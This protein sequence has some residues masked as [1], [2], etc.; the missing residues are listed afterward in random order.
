[1]ARKIRI[2]TPEEMALLRQ[3]VTEIRSCIEKL[4]NR[5]EAITHDELPSI[6]TQFDQTSA[7]LRKLSNEDI[8]LDLISERES[9]STEMKALKKEE[10]ILNH[11]LKGCLALNN[12]LS[13]ELDI[14]EANVEMSGGNAGT[15]TSKYHTRK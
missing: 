7:T 6:T 3:R 11:S 12:I 8:A 2:P 14:S 13:L 15:A 1:M 10:T 5:L 9:L 4:A